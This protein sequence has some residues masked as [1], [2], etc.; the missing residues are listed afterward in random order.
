MRLAVVAEDEREWMT[1][2]SPGGDSSKSPS[3]VTSRGNLRGA[4]SRVTSMHDMVG[5]EALRALRAPSDPVLAVLAKADD[6]RFDPFEL[7]DVTDGRPLSALCFALIRR[8]D[9]GSLQGRMG[10]VRLAKYLRTIEDGYRDLVSV[11]WNWRL[12]G[13]GVLQRCARCVLTSVPSLALAL[14]VGWQSKPV[15]AVY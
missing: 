6:W 5:A 7:S 13:R 11:G 15:V 2:P 10:E 9:L 14:V 12:P 1:P 8:L 4:P 3:R